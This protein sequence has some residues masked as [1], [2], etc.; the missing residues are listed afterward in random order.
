MVISKGRDADTHFLNVDLDIYSTHDL[1]PLV[2]ALGTTIIVLHVGRVKRTYGAHLEVAKLT[3]NADAT[4]REFCS[5][6]KCL[7]HSERQ[8]WNA[9]KIRDFNIGIQAGLQPF[10]TEFALEAETV[11][12][13]SDLG[14]RIVISVYAPE[15]GRPTEPAAK[16]DSNKA[17]RAR[18]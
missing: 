6:I 17:S 12:A 15:R 4:I 11:R 7:P 18:R 8:L 1:Q 3:K 5:L 9:T 16:T 10:C 13:T 2:T 14:A